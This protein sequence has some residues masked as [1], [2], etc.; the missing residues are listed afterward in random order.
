MKL[1]CTFN[2]PVLFLF[3]FF[4]FMS[5]YFLFLGEWGEA[6]MAVHISGHAATPIGPRAKE[7]YYTEWVTDI[8]CEEP[9]LGKWKY[10]RFM[11]LQPQVVNMLSVVQRTYW[12]HI[13]WHI[14]FAK[15]QLLSNILVLEVNNSNFFNTRVSVGQC[16]PQKEVGRAD[17]RPVKKLIM[18]VFQQ[19]QSH[20][21]T[22]SGG[23]K[24]PHSGC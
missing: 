13:S 16:T 2:P 19:W 12:N 5:F 23:F 21:V 22:S 3:S 20:S 17:A 14:T 7:M 9:L 8:P 6:C 4:L 11:I 10:G 24:T 18:P 1:C 15:N